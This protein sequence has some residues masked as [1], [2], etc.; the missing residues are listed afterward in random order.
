RRGTWWSSRETSG[1]PTATW[2]PVRRPPMRRSPWDEAETRR[3]GPGRGAGGGRNPDFSLWGTRDLRSSGLARTRDL[4]RCRPRRTRARAAVPGRRRAC[5]GAGSVPVAVLFGPHLAGGSLTRG[6]RLRRGRVGEHGD[7]GPGD[8]HQQEEH[9]DG[10]RPLVR[11]RI[12]RMV[13]AT[14]LAAVAQLV[15]P[16]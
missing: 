11:R 7:P 9:H 2:A 15:L 16:A 10:K 12:R 14:A 8:E 6:A 13:A 4:R 1:T 3:E 5:T